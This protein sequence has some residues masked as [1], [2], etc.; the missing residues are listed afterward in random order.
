M[1]SSTTGVPAR[2]NPFLRDRR[3]GCDGAVERRILLARAGCF[4]QG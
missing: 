4:A 2:A 3:D 1:P